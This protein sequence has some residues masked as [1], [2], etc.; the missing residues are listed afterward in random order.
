MDTFSSEKAGAGGLVPPASSGHAGAPHTVRVWDPLVRLF[1]WSL[2]AAFVTAWATGDEWQSVHEIAGYT[3]VGLLVFRVLWGLFGSTHARFTD[4][5]HRPSVVVGHLLDTARRRARRH[6][7]HNPAGGAMVLALLVM[8]AVICGTG[9][10]MTT[11][12]FWGVEWVEEAHEIAVNLTIVLIG[13]H[14]AGVLVASFGHGE[15]LV[16][17]MVTGRKRADKTE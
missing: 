3:I 17:A 14:I 12:A 1:H 11:D 5:V 4:F 13:L 16:A 9:I 8:L 7:G 2:V 6:L 15:N 10:L